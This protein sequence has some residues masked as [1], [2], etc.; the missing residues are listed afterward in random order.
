MVAAI[1]P[2]E[3][4]MQ[5]VIGISGMSCGSCVNAVRKALD[6]VPGVHVDAVTV[7]SATVSYDASEATAAAIDKAIRDAGYEPITEGVPVA[8]GAAGGC[9]CGH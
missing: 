5:H 7:G 6:S 1:V 4:S 2:K 3:K 8:A 9:R